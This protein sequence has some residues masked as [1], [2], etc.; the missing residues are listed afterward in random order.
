MNNWLLLVGL[1]AVIILVIAAF[2]IIQ[3]KKQKE[4]RKKHPG[5]PK[6]YYMNQGMGIGLAI[7][8]GIGVALGKIAIGI[9]IGVA[10]GA[11]IG[12]GLEKKHK[13]EIRPLTEEE[14][15][16][17]RQSIVFTTGTF[18]AGIIIFIIAYFISK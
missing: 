2:A 18:I 13:D 15:K 16:L 8:A 6:G 1:I 12:S 5:F 9:A 17:K 10:I 14:R 4:I 11:A 7:G 3:Y